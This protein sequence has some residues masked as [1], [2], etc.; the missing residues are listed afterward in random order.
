MQNV[1]KSKQMV[2]KR[3]DLKYFLQK[4]ENQKL[5]RGN[6]DRK[7]MREGDKTIANKFAEDLLAAVWRDVNADC[8]Q[9]ILEKYFQEKR[10]RLTQEYLAPSK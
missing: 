2:N 7:K 8:E 3:H 5:A 6:W 4:V 10:Y 1:N 9:N